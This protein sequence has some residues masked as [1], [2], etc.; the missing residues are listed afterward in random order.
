[1]PPSRIVQ[2]IASA[3]GTGDPAAL[4]RRLMDAGPTDILAVRMIIEPQAA[5][6]AVSNGSG[7]DIQAIREAHE[8]ATAQESLAGFE[9][10]DAMLHRCIFSATRNELL[11]SL[12]DILAAIRTRPAWSRIKN[13][14]ISPDVR[15]KYCREHAAIV[16]AIA[17]RNAQSA[18]DA[19]KHHLRSVTLDMFPQ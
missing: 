15:M 12:Q 18:H 10:W 5:A 16:E 1:M 14:V 19:M 4:L 9:H 7:A 11:I 2:H 17:A 3:A 6:A 8:N 13:T